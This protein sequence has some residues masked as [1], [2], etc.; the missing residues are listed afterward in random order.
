ME[1][2]E[3]TILSCLADLKEATVDQLVRKLESQHDEMKSKPVIAKIHE[4]LAT[5]DKAGKIKSVIKD[6]ELFYKC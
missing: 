3:Q 5:L 6:G 4:T 1:I 2:L